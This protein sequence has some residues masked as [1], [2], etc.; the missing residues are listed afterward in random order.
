MAPEDNYPKKSYEYR[1]LETSHCEL[2][3]FFSVLSY[4][5]IVGGKINC[6]L[7]SSYLDFLFSYLIGQR[8]KITLESL[9]GA[10]HRKPVLHLTINQS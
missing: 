1:I 5:Y 7:A 10:P 4:S 8:D 3:S 2:S 9:L 6:K